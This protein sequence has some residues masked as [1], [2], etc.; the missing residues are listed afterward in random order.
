MGPAAY[1][2][3]HDHSKPKANEVN[4]VADK[5]KRRTFEPT[6][7]Q[8]VNPGPGVYDF[9]VAA[10]KNFNSNGNYSVF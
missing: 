4:F 8:K 5:V 3:K 1:N 6:V 10:Q 2:P 7:D 9:E